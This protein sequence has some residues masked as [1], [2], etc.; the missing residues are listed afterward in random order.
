VWWALG[1]L[2][3]VA[4]GLPLT[5]GLA[6]RGMADRPPKPL[7]PGYGKTG[8]WLYERYGLDWRACVRIQQAVA[9][10]ERVG[11][12]ALEDAAHGLAVLTVSGRAPGQRLIR[13]AGVVWLGSGATIVVVGIVVVVLGHAPARLDFLLWYGPFMMVQAGVQTIWVPRIQRRKASRA[14]ELNRQAA[15]AQLWCRAEDHQGGGGASDSGDGGDRERRDGGRA[16]GGRRGPSGPGPD[17]GPG[18]GPAARRGGPG[19]G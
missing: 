1:V 15:T 10:G 7:R 4:V 6:T 2:V 9:R 13:V 11:D 12:P 3:V 16:G 14:L 8:Q 18:R 17:P 19:P 5:I